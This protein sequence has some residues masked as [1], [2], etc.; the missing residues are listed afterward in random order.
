MCRCGGLVRVSM[1]VL[2]VGNVGVRT[3]IL[4]LK[5]KIEI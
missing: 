5:E 4:W 1:G 3:R 2:L